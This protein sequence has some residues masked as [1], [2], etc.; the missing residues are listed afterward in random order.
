METYLVG[1]I[2]V[3]PKVILEDGKIIYKKDRSS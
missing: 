3:N 2:E 1:I